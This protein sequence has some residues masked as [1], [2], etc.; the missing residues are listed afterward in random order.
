MRTTYTEGNKTLNLLSINP[1][2]KSKAPYTL[3]F[4]SIDGK[5]PYIGSRVTPSID[6][7][8]SF[9]LSD[10]LKTAVNNPKYDGFFGKIHLLDLA[11]SD[12]P[13]R[14]LGRL[15]PAGGRISVK[16]I[17]RTVINFAYQDKRRIVR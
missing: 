2:D 9:Q 6:V 13:I 8:D 10:T 12:T 7:K 17:D 15:A 16:L 14:E 4:A 3:I 5:W 11:C 1:Q